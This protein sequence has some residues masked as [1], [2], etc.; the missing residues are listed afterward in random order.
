M[1]QSLQLPALVHFPNA[2][3][4]HP[5]R[6]CLLPSSDKLAGRVDG[7]AEDVVVVAEEEALGWF[8]DVMQ[9]LVEHDTHHS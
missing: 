5:A 7:H 8:A 3:V 1:V 9:L 6:C 4:R 2:H